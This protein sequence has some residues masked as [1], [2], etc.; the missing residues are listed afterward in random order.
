MSIN[1]ITSFCHGQSTTL[2]ANGGVVYAW[3]N[4]DFTPSVTISQGCVYTV[5][6]TNAAGCSSTAEA[7][8]TVK[9]L[10]DV[11]ISG[12]SSFCQGDTSTLTATGAITYVWSNNSTSGSIAVS[13]PG[14]YT[15]LGTD[16]NGCSNSA[17]MYVSVNPT[18]YIS[19]AQSICQG[20]VY[21]FHGMNLY[22][23]GVY[24]QTFQTVNGCDSIVTLTLTVKAS[25]TLSIS[26]NTVLC[27][28]QSTT[29]TANG[30][31]TYLW[32]NGSTNASV[33]ISQSG[34]YMVTATNTE[35][36]SS[37]A[38]V[39]VVVSPLP[40]V[41]IIGDDNFCQGGIMTLIANGAS[42]Y[43]WSDGSNTAAIT[44]TNPGVFTVIGTDANGC[45]SSASKT[46][47][48]YPSYHIQM[49]ASICQG[50]GYYFNGQ[51]LTSAGTYT[52]SFSTVNGCDSI[53]TLTLTI[54]DFPAP[55]ITGNT[56]LC[57]GQSTT[58]TA[59]G[60]N[61]YLW[62]NGSTNASTTIFQSGI[63]IV[64]ATS[65]EGC[66]SMANVTV[67]MSPL[68]TISISGNTTF[69]EGSS[70]MLIASGADTYSWSNGANTAAV[71]ISSFG[72][73][74][75]TGVSAYGCSNTATVTVLSL[76]SPQITISGET[77]I[78]A[79]ESTTLTANG[80]ESYLWSDGT[81]GSTLTVNMAGTYQVIGYNAAGCNA[82]ASATVNVWQPATSEFSIVT[83]EPCYSWNN[84]DYCE[85]G[86]YTQ[87]LQTVHGCDSVVTM[88]L[89]ITVGIDDHNLGASMTVYPNPTNDIINV[90]CTIYNVQVGTLEFHVFDAY[91]KLIGVVET[92]CTTSLQ[93]AQI[94]LS[95]YAPGVYFVKAVAD[96]KVVA[97]RKV[98]K[99]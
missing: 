64:T 36:C 25:P 82:M 30:G 97:V 14:G 21:N 80:G 58:L 16:A 57:E 52:Q 23:A 37:S 50:G 65:V 35:G 13:S 88:H 27:E 60:G 67:S 92:R 46:I 98:V 28:G 54:I 53:I 45:S 70:T 5:T 24:T 90:R 22:T 32:S 61:T 48:V 62:S 41:S 12:N 59:N 89:T 19:L 8:V 40:N 63:Y 44:V 47:S 9:P 38:N 81:T 68:P 26:G 11:H 86:T 1:G 49:A 77:D 20:E 99:R 29:L 91:G 84:I 7:T 76:A 96:D 87:T 83:E 78:C 17:T 33:I 31:N 6:A 39:S 93:T 42:S 94:D 95:R 69:C 10:P 72:L 79:G 85:S 15:V 18:Y 51:Y 56:I 66:S 2:T 73:Y 3:S 74:T 43:M 55:T 75:V 34:I 71:T 4:G